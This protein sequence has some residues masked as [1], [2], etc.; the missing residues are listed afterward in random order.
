VIFGDDPLRWDRAGGAQRRSWRSAPHRVTAA[1]VR[2]WAASAAAHD[3]A[4]Y[5]G[6][7]TNFEAACSVS[8][9]LAPLGLQRC[10]HDQARIANAWANAGNRRRAGKIARIWE[11]LLR[12]R[13]LVAVDWRALSPS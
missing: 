4:E 5:A 3:H 6:S 8:P 10:R 2:A 12:G 9:A 7:F 11:R 13:R 1:A